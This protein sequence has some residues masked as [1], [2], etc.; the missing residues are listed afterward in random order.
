MANQWVALQTFAPDDMFYEA[1]GVYDH[2][3]DHGRVAGPAVRQLQPG[4]HLAACPRCGQRFAATD[5]GTAES[6]RDLHFDGDEE[7]PSI[8]RNMPA[9]QRDRFQVL[10]GG[11]WWRLAA[12]MRGGSGGCYCPPLLA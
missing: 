1:G 11:A 2:E 12:V 6:H 10:K 4:E 8:C 7:I 3:P 5:D 9:R